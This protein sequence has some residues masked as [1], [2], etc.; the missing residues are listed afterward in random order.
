MGID[1][2]TGIYLFDGGE[3]DY[4]MTDTLN[5]AQTATRDTVLALRGEM[6]ALDLSARQSMR[7]FT[8]QRNSIADGQR[9]FLALMNDDPAWQSPNPFPYTYTSSGTLNGSFLLPAG[10]YGFDLAGSVTANTTNRSTMSLWTGL[11][12]GGDAASGG[13]LL[14][15]SSWGGVGS[16]T[17][18]MVVSRYKFSV[19]TRVW[20]RIEKTT[21]GTCNSS[22]E[23][24][25]TRFEGM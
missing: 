11:T 17:M 19:P 23:I 7:K 2:A 3:P 22:A 25:V 9:Y 16:F 4:P 8:V 13:S 5:L 10:T 20:F 18:N 14:R 24:I 6:A 12:S 1:T 21:G 15:D